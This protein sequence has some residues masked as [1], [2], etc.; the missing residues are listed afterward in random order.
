M[1]LIIPLD[2]NNTMIC[3]IELPIPVGYEWLQ[4]LSASPGNITQICWIDEGSLQGSKLGT[5]TFKAKFD[6]PPSR[7]GSK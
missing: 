6:G 2:L 4:K 1:H 3:P 7:I 5:H